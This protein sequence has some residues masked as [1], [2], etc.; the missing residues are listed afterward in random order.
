MLPLEPTDLLL[1]MALL[2]ATLY[3]IFGLKD[4]RNR[5]RLT[6]FLAT[7]VTL[8][9]ATYL[10]LVFNAMFRT[11]W[12]F[13][14]SEFFIWGIASLVMLLGFVAVNA[15][16]ALGVYGLGQGGA[17][18]LTRP[19]SIPVRESGS[20][21]RIRREKKAQQRAWSN[22]S[23]KLHTTEVREAAPVLEE[24]TL[25]P[26]ASTEPA[27]QPTDSAAEAIASPVLETPIKSIEP[28]APPVQVVEEKVM[29]E[30]AEPLPTEPSVEIPKPEAAD[31]ISE[32]D[33][34]V[35]E[36]PTAPVETVSPIVV[37][38]PSVDEESVQSDKLLE[39]KPEDTGSM[40][41]D[42]NIEEAILA[43]LAAVE[44]EES[45]NPQPKI[46]ETAEPISPPAK[47]AA[48]MVTEQ[49]ITP[50][51]TEPAPPHAPEPVV[52]SEEELQAKQVVLGKHRK[53]RLAAAELDRK[54]GE[55]EKRKRQQAEEDAWGE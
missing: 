15:V 51:I 23:P 43:A 42:P 21:R 24:E 48:V 45:T 55:W 3:L 44:G 53:K 4:V 19:V 13:S 10:A 6:S 52:E 9:A 18:V 38:T 1:L 41:K 47:A 32:P 2:N 35:V 49:R 7:S 20:G 33:L 22:R 31:P 25:P 46:V 29:E 50:E 40:S 27:E 11:H 8:G 28:Q 17:W 34:P 36:I 26:Q 39:P 5:V 12:E 16:F 30:P 54:R 14:W 37:E